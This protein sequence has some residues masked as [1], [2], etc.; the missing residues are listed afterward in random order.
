MA[1]PHIEFI[2][3]QALPWQPSPWH[4]PGSG[5]EMRV[6]SR[7]EE[8][9]ES[10]L[11]VR[12][13]KGWSRPGETYLPVDEELFVLGGALEINGVT[14]GDKCYAHLPAGYARRSASSR[15]GAVVLTF[16][17]GDP[18]TIAGAPPAGLYDERRLVECIDALT[19]PLSDDFTKLGVQTTDDSAN[20]L[21]ACAHLIFRNDPETGDQTW[22]LCARPLWQGGVEEIHP[23][24]EEMYLV[25]GE[26]ATDTGWMKPGAYFW[27]PAGKR[28]GPFGSKTGNMMFFRT[29]GGPLTT[30]YP[31]RGEK[32]S[33]T[34]EHRPVLPPELLK[35]GAAPGHE[36][37][38]Y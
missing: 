21:V 34:P 13:P 33:W 26:M 17:S 22:I 10:S 5:I 2:Q 37:V 11:L 24:V 16:Y 4:E 32:F 31:G 36:E 35:Y 19:A 14:Y 1:R 7:D 18:E 3:A 12:Y 20:G 23:V 27:R 15:D 38:P 25:A 8:T 9:H 30:T 6:L 29:K 28:H